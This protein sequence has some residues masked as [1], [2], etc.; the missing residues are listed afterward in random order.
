MRSRSGTYQQKLTQ[1]PIRPLI[2]GAVIVQDVSLPQP[3]LVA[4][5][6]D[7]NLH[8]IFVRSSHSR[9]PSSHA[10]TSAC[11]HARR[12]TCQHVSSDTNVC[13][14]QCSFVIKKAFSC[15]TSGLVY[16]ISLSWRMQTLQRFQ[17]TCNSTVKGPFL[18]GPF[19]EIP[20]N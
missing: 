13:G 12:L 20:G 5:R 10:G 11:L 6:R 18:W 7:S 2:R 1:V 14:P 16:C 19:L 3:P 9:Q 15:Q 4:Y 17:R 8:D